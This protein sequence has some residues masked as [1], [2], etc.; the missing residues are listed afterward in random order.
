MDAV[1]I[2]Y[3]HILS[4]TVLFG[5]GIGTAFYLLCASLGREPRV[6]AAVARYVVIGDW[7]FTATTVIAQPLTGFYL[8]H[9][10]GIP[11]ATDW[12]YWSLVLFAIAV[13]CWIPVVW[14]QIRLRDLAVAAAERGEPLPD[15]YGAYLGAW[16]AL[17][18]PALLCFLGVFYLMTAKPAQLF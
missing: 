3:L 14:L 6:V 2:K 15:R 10:L 13:A 4:S 17:G 12:V 9:R 16:V 8:L 5:T 1:L 11:L 18:I 7:L